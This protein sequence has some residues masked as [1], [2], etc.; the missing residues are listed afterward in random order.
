M[1]ENRNINLYSDSKYIKKQNVK[2]SKGFLFRLFL[3]KVIQ[4]IIF[5][6]L[7]GGMLYGG[8]YVI[9]N[10]SFP[11]SSGGTVLVESDTELKVD[12]YIAFSKTETMFYD[13]LLLTLDFEKVEVA[14]I[15]GLPFSITSIGEKNIE[16][17]KDEY[18]LED[19][20]GNRFRIKENQI[21]GE[22]IE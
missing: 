16:V 3:N 2:L 22:V 9:T 12:S 20:D 10:K 15:V 4:I 8:Y 21:Y 11:T 19:E 14:K 5:L 1:S 13:K 17:P 18:V 7:V 6:S